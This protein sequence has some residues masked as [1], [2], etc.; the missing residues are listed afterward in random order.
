MQRVKRVRRGRGEEGRAEDERR[1]CTKG[2]RA[3][4]QGNH[5]D[6]FVLKMN[7]KN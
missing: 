5:E 3:A 1:L 2:A 4:G 7:R 6:F